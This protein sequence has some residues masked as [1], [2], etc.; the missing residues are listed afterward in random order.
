MAGKPYKVAKRWAVEKGLG[1]GQLS[2]FDDPDVQAAW[3]KWIDSAALKQQVATA[4]NGMWT[5]WTSR[6]GGL[7]PAASRPGD[8]RRGERRRGHEGRRRQVERVSR[9][10]GEELTDTERRRPLPAAASS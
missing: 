10:D 3:N 5:E 6:L 8:G 7:F 2:L 9:Q 4:R 1:F